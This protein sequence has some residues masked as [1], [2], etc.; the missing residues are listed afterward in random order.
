MKSRTNETWKLGVRS[1]TSSW[2]TFLRVKN[3]L[4]MVK[5]Y[6]HVPCGEKGLQGNQILM[7]VN[8][9]TDDLG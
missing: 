6:D 5:K 9:C 7:V 2:T 8:T 4:R 1:T 3:G